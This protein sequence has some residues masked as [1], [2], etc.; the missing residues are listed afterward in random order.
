MQSWFTHFVSGSISKNH[1]GEKKSLFLENVY[2]VN[3]ELAVMTLPFWGQHDVCDT[4]RYKDFTDRLFAAPTF[5]NDVDTGLGTSSVVIDMLSVQ[6]R[7]HCLRQ[8]L[9]PYQPKMLVL[10]PIDRRGPYSVSCRRN[11]IS[12]ERQCHHH[13]VDVNDVYL[14]Q[15]KIFLNL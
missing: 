7:S 8:V 14:F 13:W 1:L 11:H 12:P 5:T 2:V 4:M 15:L 3:L 6:Q 9:S 10:R